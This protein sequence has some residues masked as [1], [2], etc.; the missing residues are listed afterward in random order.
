MVGIY[1]FLE[2]GPYGDII[3]QPT[4]ANYARALDPLYLRI[5][6]KSFLLAASTTAVCAL[7]G[8]P[9]AYTIATAAKRWQPSLMGLLM[10]PF[11]T[12]FVV[13]VYAIRLILAAEGPINLGL[14]SLGLI[15]EPIMM[16]DSTM[17][18][19]LGMITNYLPFMVL[20]I[21]VVFEKFDFAIIEAA[22]DLGAKGWPVF[23]RVI[24]PLAKPGLLSGLSLV[25]VP[26][27]GEYMIPDLLG[28]A[29]TLMLGGLITEQFLR[30]R[31]WPFGAALAMILCIAMVSV[32]WLQHRYRGTMASHGSGGRSGYSRR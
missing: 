14:L 15:T 21:Y 12:N 29:K 28:G 11:L 24:L 16:T 2:R 31:D 18:V 20:P 19:A 13:R 32:L 3:W 17:A 4:L 27:L 1:S 25:F 8:L 5:Y 26:V 6:R 10:V 22:K 30:V 9:L 7:L 23:S